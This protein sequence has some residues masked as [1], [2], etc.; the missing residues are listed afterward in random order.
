MIAFVNNDTAFPPGW[1]S[2]LT[3]TM[4]GRPQAGLVL[5]AVTAAGNP[6]SVRSK[7]GSDVI[8]LIPFGELPSGVVYLLRTSVVRALGGWNEAY[9]VASAEDLDLCF[10]V[11]ANDLEVVLDTRVLVEH[12]GQATVRPRLPERKELY[13]ANLERF[14]D[15]WTSDDP[16]VPRLASCPEEVFIRNLG[17]ART[18]AVWIRRLIHER[19]AAADAPPPAPAPRRRRWRS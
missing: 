2:L 17:R 4:D 18:A 9:P 15:R 3:A 11:W 13:R 1:A 7:P 6:V 19:R 16:A 14:L 12:V 8:A 10:T 5:P